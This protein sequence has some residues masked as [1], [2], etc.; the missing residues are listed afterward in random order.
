[1]VLYK[2]QQYILWAECG[3]YYAEACG[4]NNNLWDLKG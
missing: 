2:E 3:V 4:K 1:L